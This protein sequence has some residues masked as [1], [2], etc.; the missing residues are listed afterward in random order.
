M[1]RIE[2]DPRNVTILGTG[3]P[4][5]QPTTGPGAWLRRHRLQIAGI[6]ALVEGVAFAMHATSRI[7]LLAL[8]VAVI[9]LHFYVGPHLPYTL[10][11][12]TWTLALAQA[13]VAVFSLLLFVVSVVLA[14]VLFAVLASLVLA[15]IAMLLGDRR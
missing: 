5:G 2:V 14:F 9:A 12:V 4:A 11:Q 1:R 15:G 13:L 6:L 10:R 7:V 3:S 8:A